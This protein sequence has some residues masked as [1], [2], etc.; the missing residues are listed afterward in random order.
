MWIFLGTE[1]LFF[2][3]LLLGYAYAR[4]HWPAGFVEASRHADVFLG[5]LNTGLLLTSSAVVAAAVTRCE[6]PAR[7][8]GR[9]S[10]EEAE[11]VTGHDRG[12][13]V[14]LALA[15]AIGLAFLGVKLL[16]YRH[17]LADGLF[18]GTGFRLAG[19]PGARL[20]FLL[21][22]LLTGVHAV[23][24]AVGTTAMAALAWGAWRRRAWFDG[25]RA[26]AAGLY[27]HFIDVIWIFLYPLL[28][29]VARPG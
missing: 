10:P 9:E 23:H 22:F 5:T 29:L 15:A 21:Y 8:V 26:E 6:T 28:Y 11:S 13:A 2:G 17:E 4:M 14:L 18:P 27:W 24:L 1:L 16:E 19:D 7:A 20:F 3:P 12:I 25:G